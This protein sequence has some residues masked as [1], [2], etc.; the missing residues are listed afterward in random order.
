MKIEIFVGLVVPDNTASTARRTAI[1]MGFP[2]TDIKRDEY[3]CF[4]AESDVSEKLAKTDVLVNANKH[5]CVIRKDG[6][7]IAGE[8]GV[9]KILVKDKEDSAAAL[10][11]TLKERLGIQSINSMSKGTLWTLVVK[12]GGKEVAQKIAEELL[13]NKHYQEYEFYE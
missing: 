1:A 9:F 7:A 12:E 11:S 10:L 2:I 6:E 5:K 8:E 4:D 13:S 3:Y